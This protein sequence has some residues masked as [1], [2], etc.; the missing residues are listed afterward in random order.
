MRVEHVR[1]V[2]CD[3]AAQPA[4]A[5]NTTV[6]GNVDT[7][8][9]GDMTTNNTTINNNI[10]IVVPTKELADAMLDALRDPEVQSRLATTH[11]TEVPALMFQHARGSEAPGRHVEVKGGHVIEK[12]PNGELKRVPRSKYIKQTIGAAMDVCVRDAGFIDAP[13]V[14]ETRRDLQKKDLPGPR[15]R[16]PAVSRYE[17]AKMY[18][19][20]DQAYYKVPAKGKEYVQKTVQALDKEL[21]G[22][23]VAATPGTA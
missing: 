12:R 22:C 7:L 21:D 5:V 23:E 4:P 11:A 2:E 1:M 14:V 6:N 19:L 17:V 8:V 13:A 16:G 10:T 18:A 3:G 9:N 15:K 20:G